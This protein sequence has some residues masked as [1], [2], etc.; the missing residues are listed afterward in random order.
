MEEALRWLPEEESPSPGEQKSTLDEML[1]SDR[2]K[3]A[4]GQRARLIVA[5]DNLDMRQYLSRLLADRYD[6]VAVGDGEAALAAARER[7]PNLILSDVMM[8]H[9]DGFGL[10]RRIRQDSLLRTVPI[11]LLSARA[12]EESRVEGLQEGADDYLIKP[13]SARELMA[14]VAAHLELARVRKEAEELMRYRTEQFE[15]LLNQAPLGVYWS[16]PISGSG[17]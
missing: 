16:M 11:I 17:R 6:V 9:L 14:R 13:F 3:N 15:T 1:L 10:L 2:K 12:G 5:D 4:N 7:R 8:P